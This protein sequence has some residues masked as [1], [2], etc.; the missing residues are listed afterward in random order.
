MQA[1]SSG[2][3]AVM[4][5]SHSAQI[6]GVPGSST[7]VTPASATAITP[8]PT[9]SRAKI[10]IGVAAVVLAA[11]VA[12]GYFGGWF[13]HHATYTQAELKPQ[14]LT[15]NSSEDPVTGTS[16]SPDG[17]YLVFADL[18]G[19]HLRLMSSGETQTLP[20]PDAFCFR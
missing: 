4:T 13:G 18:E 10:Y 19:L 11:I 9:K 16:V 15:S 3:V 8:V 12:G 2:A 14:M 7:A 5:D 1:G 20:T 6:A 17:K